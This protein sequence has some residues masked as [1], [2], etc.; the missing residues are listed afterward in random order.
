LTLRR[1]PCLSV[2]GPDFVA[3]QVRD[4]KAAAQF[5]EKHL[6]SPFGPIFSFTG[7]EGYV[8]THGA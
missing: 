1:H 6:A 2:D 7:P 5:C 8:L 4:V 3:L